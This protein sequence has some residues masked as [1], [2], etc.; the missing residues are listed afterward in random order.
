M[1][2]ST[3]VSL[4]LAR[5]L[6]RNLDVVANNIANSNTA[7]FKAERPDFKDLVAQ[8]L[9]H[10]GT[11]DVSF[12]REAGSHIDT[13]PGALLKTGN[14]LD[15]AITGDGWFG[16]TTAGGATAFGR[17]GRLTIDAQGMLATT[18]G[19]QVL[20]SGGAPIAIPATTGGRLSIAAD[21]TISDAQGNTIGKLGIF[22]VPDIA[23]YQRIGDGMMAPPDGTPAPRTQADGVQ[24]SQGFIE[25]SNVEPVVEM[26]RMIDIQRAYERA[27]KLI[28]ED[29]S[30]RQ[31]VLTQ[32]GQSG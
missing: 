26:T 8:K 7:G 11:E 16:Y 31:Q 3:F 30:L 28:E 20:D 32:L 25:Q 29:D 18:T 23:A 22:S 19:A 4:S 13:R 5:S 1:D 12:V 27:M 9:G 14:P 2:N 15:V 21:G 17:D 6:E 10:A 24:V